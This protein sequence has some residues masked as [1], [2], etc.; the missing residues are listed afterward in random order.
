MYLINCDMN[1]VTVDPQIEVDERPAP[2]S[3][4]TTATPRQTTI[5][6]F[7]TKDEVLKAEILWAL[8]GIVPPIIQVLSRYWNTLSQDVPR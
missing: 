3:T 1:Y 5:Q 7:V 4:A 2:A 8:H 6:D